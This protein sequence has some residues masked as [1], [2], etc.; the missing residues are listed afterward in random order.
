MDYD[1]DRIKQSTAEEGQLFL[2]YEFND[3]DID[4]SFVDEIENIVASSK[5]VSGKDE[6]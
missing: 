3:S 2:N 5:L 6:Y 1:D 4:S